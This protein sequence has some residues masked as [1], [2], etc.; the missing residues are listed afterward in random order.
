MQTMLQAC[1]GR[2]VQLRN[3]T[4]VKIAPRRMHSHGPLT[5]SNALHW[6]RL[7]QLKQSGCEEEVRRLMVPDGVPLLDGPASAPLLLGA[8]S[9]ATSGGLSSV[10]VDRSPKSRLMSCTLDYSVRGG[11]GSTHHWRKAVIIGAGLQASVLPRQ[12]L[13]CLTP[14][15]S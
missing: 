10:F 4:Q 6:Q 1:A 2:F 14:I 7:E 9:T 8:T 5:V 12:G 11:L 15:R 13:L 3:S